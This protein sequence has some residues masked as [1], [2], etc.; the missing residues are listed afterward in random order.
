MFNIHNF[1][2]NLFLSLV[3]RNHPGA[4][5]GYLLEVI[6]Y[7]RGNRLDARGNPGFYTNYEMA[8]REDRVSGKFLEESL[9]VFK[10][11]AEHLVEIDEPTRLEQWLICLLAA[12][13]RNSLGSLM[14]V[15]ASELA[16]LSA[17]PRSIIKSM[18][19]SDVLSYDYSYKGYMK[20]VLH[21]DALAFLKFR[22]VKGF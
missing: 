4:D 12:Q 21:Q 9:D 14:G 3:N 18:M 7:A 2:I 17:T 15:S 8:I 1:E 11:T 20:C 5:P 6:Q 10:Q 16:A 19:A 22:G 13:A